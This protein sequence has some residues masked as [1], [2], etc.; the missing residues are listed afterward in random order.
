[1][2]ELGYILV[3]RE[4]MKA[5]LHPKL[6]ITKI[7]TNLSHQT[8]K[9]TMETVLSTKHAHINLKPYLITNI[10]TNPFYTIL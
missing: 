3:L 8:I 6:Q 7:K 10:T 5:I 4:E 9:T 2:V 1:M